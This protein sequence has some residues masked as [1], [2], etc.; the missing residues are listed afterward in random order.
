LRGLIDEL[1]SSVENMANSLDTEL[2]PF[3]ESDSDSL[4]LDEQGIVQLIESF[5]SLFDVFIT[6]LPSLPKTF[7]AQLEPDTEFFSVINN[8]YFNERELLQVCDAE[9]NTS[10]LRK[11]RDASGIYG[12]PEPLIPLSTGGTCEKVLGYTA[13]IAGGVAGAAAGAV[14][15]PAIPIP[16][17]LTI[18]AFTKAGSDVGENLGSAVGRVL[19][20]P[21]T[22]AKNVNKSLQT[23][24]DP[25]VFA[26][27]MGLPDPAA[28][29]GNGE[30]NMFGP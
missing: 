9:V 15:A 22:V 21:D 30:P 18:A 23:L 17:K 19:D 27:T 8:R 28:G 11:G 10:D 20:N 14:V 6:S 1:H 7:P 13:A 5:K 29:G 12:G 2:L 4:V 16:P 3:D 26:V 25:R 24:L